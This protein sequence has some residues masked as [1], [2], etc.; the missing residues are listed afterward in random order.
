MNEYI[1][2]QCRNMSTV[3]AVF[4]QAC[5]LA[6]KEDDGMIS[7]QE[8]KVL[9]RIKRAAKVFRRELSRVD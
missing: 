5:E 3:I 8:E 1:K 4:E 9:H 2:T 6:A 7:R